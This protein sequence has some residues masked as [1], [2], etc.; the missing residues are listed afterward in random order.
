MKRFGIE[1]LLKE[2]KLCIY[3]NHFCLI[4]K[5]QNVSFNKAIKEVKDNFKIVH[6]FITE[7]NVNS[8]F[9]YDFTPKKIDSPL[10]NSLVYDIET[11]N[12]DRARP[13]CI[14]L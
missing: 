4:W 11:H 9:K 6:K 12:T 2:K 13:Y 8:H 14:F 5:S 7:E 3:N 10:T 1:M